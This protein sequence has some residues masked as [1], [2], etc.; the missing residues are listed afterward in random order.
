M[1]AAVNARTSPLESIRGLELGMVLYLSIVGFAQADDAYAVVR[2]RK[3]QNMQPTV[4]P[5][6][7]DVPRLAIFTSGVGL[8]V[9]SLELELRCPFEWQTALTNVSLVLVRIE[10]DAHI[11]LYVQLTFAAR[12][13]SHRSRRRRRR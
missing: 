13:S 1:S 7:R 10:S 4:K 8:D 11:K 5:A 2:F 6:K 3:T 9:R 12:R